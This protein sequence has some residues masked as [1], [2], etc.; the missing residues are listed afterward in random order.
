MDDGRRDYY[1]VLGVP[2]DASTE[3]IKRAFR[4]LAMKYHPDRNRSPEAEARFKEIN[5]AYEVL[6]DPEKRAAYDRFGH[7]G[8]Q[9]GAD[10]GRPFEGFRFGGFG[11]I[12]DAFFGGAASAVRR[13]AQRGAD[14][15]LELELD[16]AEAA[17]GCDKEVEVTR[18][19]RCP[20]CGGN[21]CEPGSRPQACPSCGGSGQVR[22]VQ[23]SFFGQFINVATCPQCRGEGSVIAHP[24]RDCR[25]S[26]RQRRSRRLR[27]QVPPGVDEGTQMR[28]SGE[29]D[30]GPNGGP[31]GNL[32]VV[33]RLRPHPLF[34]RE[35]YDL[36]YQLDLNLAQAALGCE[37]QVPT[38]EG[39]PCTLRVPPGTQ[40][41]Q[42]F[43]LKGRG[44]PHLAGGGRGDL[45]VRIRLTV[46]RELTPQQRQLLEALAASFGTPV[47]SDG[48]RG[49]LGRLRDALS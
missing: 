6:S 39:E 7:D 17:F 19:E 38:L 37:V 23:R 49:L 47:S 20:R 44:V 10:F 13:E 21:G 9:G 18:V 36:V 4:R 29:G 40:H 30:A 24:C 41:G 15:R 33:V 42:E 1:R 22:R 35:G 45:R 25:G 26:G 2:R 12:F 5:E 34:Q 43:T 11:D 32:Y 46:P 8:L 27:I 3:E 28:V 48:D 31:T 16:L 14:R